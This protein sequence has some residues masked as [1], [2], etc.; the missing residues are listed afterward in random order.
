MTN[1]RIAR[2]GQF[3]GSCPDHDHGKRWFLRKVLTVMWFVSESYLT[4]FEDPLFLAMISRQ[5]VLE[6]VISLFS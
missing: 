4:D 3:G 2:I 5:E 6:K 1:C